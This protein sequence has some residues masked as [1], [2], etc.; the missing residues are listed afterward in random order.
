MNQP[1][2]PVVR[3]GAAIPLPPPQDMVGDI[4]TD[5][6]AGTR[7]RYRYSTGRHYELDFGRGEATF[8]LIDAPGYQAAWGQRVTVRC[9]ATELRG[10]LVLVHWMGPPAGGG[11]ATLVVDLEGRALHSASLMPFAHTELFD[12][13]VIDFIGRV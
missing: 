2:D 5:C 6:L 12:R 11:H 1:Q 3:D 10:G 13:A 9:R 7:I 4:E 8:H